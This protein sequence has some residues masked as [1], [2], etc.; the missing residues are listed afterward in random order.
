MS[1][2][3]FAKS[4]KSNIIPSNEAL[5]KAR[6]EH[7]LAIEQAKICL[8]HKDFIKYAEQYSKA[9]QET[10]QAMFLI[11]QSEFDPLKYAFKMK[12]IVARLRQAKLLLNSVKSDAG[13][14]GKQDDK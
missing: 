12:E 7:G 1:L 6:E 4:G 11:D 13:Q 8:Q 10:I 2:L 3:R 14:L 5:E 9:E